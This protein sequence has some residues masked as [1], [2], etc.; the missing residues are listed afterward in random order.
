MLILVGSEFQLFGVEIENG[1]S[2]KEVPD[3]GIIDLQSTDD[4]SC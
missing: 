4:L 1:L 2:Y 3:L